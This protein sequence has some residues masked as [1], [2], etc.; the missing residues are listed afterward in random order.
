[1]EAGTLI[2]HYEVAEKLGEGGMGEVYKA[3]DRQLKRPVALKF[4]RASQCSPAQIARFEQEARVVAALNHAN[5]ATI[6]EI[7]QADGR[8]FLAFEYLAGGTLKAA[9]DQLR[10][11]G[12]QISLEQGLEYAIQLVEALAYAHREGVIHRDIKNANV[13]FTASGALKLTDFG[14][15]KFGEGIDVTQT[16][17]VM[18]TPTTMSPE[19]A[20]GQETDE[21][22]DVFSVGVVLF[23]LF[24][25]EMP[26]K[27]T[28]T[29]AIIYQVV[30]EPAPRLSQLRPNVPPVLEQI[31]A[32]ALQKDP[33]ARYQSAGELA[34]DLRALRRNL[35]MGTASSLNDVETVVLTG[36]RSVA[37][38]P[39]WWKRCSRRKM[40]AASILAAAGIVLGTWL[41]WPVPQTRLAILPFDASADIG[42]QAP[43]DGFREL[44]TAELT[45]V[46][47][48]RGAGLVVLPVDDQKQTI[49]PSE[50]KSKLG[51]DLVLTGKLI[52]A[53]DSPRLIVSLHDSARSEELHSVG[54]DIGTANL[55]QAADRVFKM[56]DLGALTRLR[57]SLKSRS[58]ATPEAMRSFIEGRGLLVRSNFDAAEAAFRDAVKRD[59]KYA[60]AWAGLADTLWHQYHSQTDATRLTEASQFA[61]RSLAID[62]GLADAHLILSQIRLDQSLKDAAEQELKAALKLQPAN[63]RAYMALGSLYQLKNDFVNAEVTYRKAI[64]MRPGDAGGY[65]HLGDLYYKQQRPELLP[66]AA[67]EFLLAIDLAPYNYKA[68][69][70]LGGVY[71]KME[72]YADAI[73]QFKRS[74]L[75]APSVAAHSNLGTAY[76]YAGHYAEAVEEYR[77]ATERPGASFEYWG[78][79]A[80]A[81]RWAGR[82]TEAQ[83]SYEKAI[84]LLKSDAGVRGAL[85]HAILAMYSISVRHNGVLLPR[86]AEE[87]RKEIVA[88]RMEPAANQAVEPRVEFNEVL[89]Y[90]Q[91]GELDRAF[92][93]LGKLARTAPAMLREIARTPALR[94]LRKDPRYIQ[95]VGRKASKD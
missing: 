25:G 15:A 46:E 61:E 76:Y 43:V 21:R 66:E 28:N 26:F 52:Q 31:V 94:E 95:T 35:E 53:G 23:E 6:H 58:A 75:I 68:V 73:E 32:K 60:P 47:R 84:G 82:E 57:H 38:G 14:L 78:N 85:R 74:I 10:S 83:A 5:I 71:L 79:L 40:M 86:N 12:Q 92:E 70:N 69:S 11:A 34:Q 20:R 87:A 90:A 89:V 93:A 2:S 13:M 33:A 77:Y 17:T 88:A 39:A 1:M 63:A 7:N 81:Y 41:A 48:P 19:Q 45:S 16:G 42:R 8:P 56:L 72:R 36:S 54:I 67:H 91:L 64:E 29:A 50:A 62:S 9:L 30:H 80:D 24:S 3:W 65:N 51:A 18:G 44:L 22:S 59:P 4:L 27:G 37:E 49:S 55:P